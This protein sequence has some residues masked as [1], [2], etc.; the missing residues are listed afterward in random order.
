MH[1]FTTSLTGSWALGLFA[2][3]SR[4]RTQGLLCVAVWILAGCTHGTTTPDPEIAEPET[5]TEMSMPDGSPEQ[6]S[7]QYVGLSENEARALAQ[8][9]G[10]AFRVVQRDGQRL[11]VTF[12][13]VRGR[14]N[15]EVTG[16]VVTSVVVEGA[17][18][19]GQKD[20]QPQKKPTVADSC[21]VFFDGCNHCR[22]GAPGGAAACTKKACATYEPVRCLDP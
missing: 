17:N 7:R 11:M 1:S 3:L 21:L 13:F 22:R 9:R 19:S 2:G 8:Q 5:T 16:G 12:D 4:R 10:T 20:S 15:A 6:A 18:L 14:I